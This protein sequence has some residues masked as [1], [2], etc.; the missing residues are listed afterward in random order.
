MILAVAILLAFASSVSA[1]C[2]N[3]CSGH[4]TCMTDEVCSCYDNW[5]VGLNH[6]S[7]DCSDRICP[8]ELAWVDT[9]DS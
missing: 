9:P 7:G 2:D 4:G 8:F 1:S 5:G 6:D 3:N